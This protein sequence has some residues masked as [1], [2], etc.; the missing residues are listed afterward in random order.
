M[1]K[2]YIFI[3]TLILIIS[4]LIFLISSIYIVS[5]IN[6]K[7]TY[8]TIKNYLAIAEASFDGDNMDKV[9]SRI[10]SSNTDVRVTFISGDG[11]V[12]YDTSETSE[13]NHLNREEIKN[14]GEIFCRYSE[15]TKINRYYLA[16]YDEATDIYIRVSIP[17]S[18]VTGVVTRYSIYGAIGILLLSIVSFLFI[19]FS[20]KRLVKPLKAEINNLSKITNTNFDYHGD[21]LN[22]LSSQIETVRKI[23]D[24]NI[25]SIKRET[26][27]L[28][29]IIDHMSSGIIIIAGNKNIILIN[30]LALKV[31]NK[32]REDLENKEY[33]NQF[34]MLN[35]DDEIERAMTSTSSYKDVYKIG[36]RFYE[37]SVNS[38]DV[39]F[40]ITDD[41]TGA[42]V[43]IQDITD[44]KK[45]E[46][47]KL[48]FF[49]N[50]SHELKSPLTSVIGYQQMIGEG[51]ITDDEEIMK[52][53]AKTIKEARRMNQIII[54]MLELSKLE[55]E[56]SVEKKDLSLANALDEV[57]DSFE[58]IIKEKNISIE[59]EYNDF[60]ININIEE[61][62][63]VLRNLVENAIK[64][65]KEN[66]K[67][68]IKL[69]DNTLSI[70]DTGI[71]ISNDNLDRIF[72]RFYRV[73]KA[74]SKELGGTGLGL[75]IVKHICLNNNIKIEVKS[76]L[77]EGTEF[78][79]KF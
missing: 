22:Q 52:A 11:T 67:I 54:E 26:L 7:N 36:D 57:I 69:G 14:L 65:N 60:N 21:D 24:S 9:A 28:N 10:H 31:L 12:L 77:N 71:G 39:D 27:K 35:I 53:T 8:K 74:K 66:G 72:E 46:Q 45:L 34:E 23:I 49:A 42:F 64:Y 58:V 18:S 41:K 61:L 15:T 17:E 56:Q 2:K 33:L 40:V 29:Y 6:K 73:D 43:F 1:R 59:K 19:Y 30:D 70:R 25:Q 76:K 62:Y 51:I 79:L 4:L 63:H 20:S 32:K 44:S 50:A 13:D 47:V 75:A 48:D 68:F 55:M 37:I 3:N 5:D 38:L 16:S 78:I